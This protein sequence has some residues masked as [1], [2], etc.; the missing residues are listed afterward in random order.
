MGN[1]V[2][3]SNNVEMFLCP[4]HTGNLRLSRGSCASMWQRARSERYEPYSPIAAC[5]G[6]SLGAQH[7]GKSDEKMD[8][9]PGH[10]DRICTRCHRPSTRFVYGC[11]CVSC[12][13][14]GRE[15]L[16]G[17]NAR[18]APPKRLPPML[19]VDVAYIDGGI[20]RRVSV[21][22]VSDLMEAKLKMVRKTRQILRF[23][24]A[25]PQN[26]LRQMS[27]FGGNG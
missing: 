22:L 20:T 11:I 9:R 27:L 24:H 19:D 13:N 16:L 2:D 5:Y 10:I 3:V 25:A 6:C 17:K 21:G 18:G 26:H 8:R 15:V 7:A 12:Y 1:L 23:V 4:N 14:R